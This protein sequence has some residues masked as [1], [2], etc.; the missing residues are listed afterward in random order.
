MVKMRRGHPP[1]IYPLPQPAVILQ[2][3]R[4][5]T[6]L[7][8]FKYLRAQQESIKV[9]LF[10]TMYGIRSLTYT[11]KPHTFSLKHTQGDNHKDTVTHSQT[12]TLGQTNSD[13]HSD[14]NRH[15]HNFSNRPHQGNEIEI[16]YVSQSVCVY[17]CVYVTFT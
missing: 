6:Y 16:T 13:R 1:K 7:L 10:C 9:L 11:H 8:I 3:S 4:N 12:D 15:T 17:M 5:Q 2:E 14:S